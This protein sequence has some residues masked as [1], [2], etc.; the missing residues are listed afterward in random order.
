MP[1]L[2]RV[3]ISLTLSVCLGGPLRAASS[4]ENLFQQAL[5]KESG[6]RDLEGAIALYQKVIDEPGAERLAIFEARF[7]L[8]TCYERLGKT[9]E[10]QAVYRQ[11]LADASAPPSE[12]ARETQANL[13]RLEA[14]DRAA[15]QASASAQM[16]VSR[17]FHA[18]NASFSIGPALLLTKGESTSGLSASFRYRLSSPSRPLALYIDLNGITPF[19]SSSLHEE[20]RVADAQTTDHGR[21]RLRY[22]VSAA[23]VAELPHG[24]Q[25]KVI[26][27][28]GVG[29][30]L[31]GADLTVTS[32]YIGSS[33]PASSEEKISRKTLSPMVTTGLHFFP[34]QVISFILQGTCVA[35]PFPS[36]MDLAS[37]PHRASFNAPSPLWGVAGKI[38]LKIGWY[39]SAK[40]SAP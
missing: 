3:L 38:Q 27:N 31:T 30:A 6:E 26:P 4:A 2:R 11:I 25:R 23:V 20:T 33:Y 21:L 14:Q 34:D 12:I 19:S 9:Q 39:K 22:Q 16:K 18:T 40:S 37:P 13:R 17:E 10:A 5:V 7:R 36:S 8:G 28:I 35:N 24:V 15:A 32:A 1:T 29:L